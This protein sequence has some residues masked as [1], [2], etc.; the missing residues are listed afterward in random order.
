MR[1]IQNATKLQIAS[2]FCKY[3][4]NIEH[5]VLQSNAYIMSS[6][7]SPPQLTN[8]ICRCSQII[9]H[10]GEQKKDTD[11]PKIRIRPTIKKNRGRGRDLEVSC[12]LHRD[13][14]GPRFWIWVFKQYFKKKINQ[15]ADFGTKVLVLSKN[16]TFA[17]SIKNIPQHFFTVKIISCQEKLAIQMH[18]DFWSGKRALYKTNDL[19]LKKHRNNCQDIYRILVI[20]YVQCT[21]ILSKILIRLY[22][23]IRQDINCILIVGRI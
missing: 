19:M 12:C 16:F 2:C 21:L 18:L 15:K 23:N 3:S 17:K 10:E 22:I 7:L 5:H 13:R 6:F 14:G 4:L 20:V 8:V 9:T 1:F 11:S